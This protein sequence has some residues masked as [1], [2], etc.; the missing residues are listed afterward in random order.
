M[1]LVCEAT[2]DRRHTTQRRRYKL[3]FAFLLLANIMW[4][5]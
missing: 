5:A 3:R 1:P 4:R 2:G